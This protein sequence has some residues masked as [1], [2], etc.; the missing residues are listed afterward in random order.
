LRTIATLPAPEGLEDRVM[1]ALASTRQSARGLEWR[2]ISGSQRDWLR[3]AAAAAIVFVVAGGGWGIYSRVQPA[4]PAGAKVLA[5][6]HVGAQ[7]GFSSA[8]AMRMPQTLNG[9]AAP[10]AAQPG[11][12]AKSLH[13]A[14][15]G[16]GQK[17]KTIKSKTSVRALATSVN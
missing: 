1:D 9:P 7:S 3:A 16:S 5:P 12:A 6:A 10:V 17:G 15:Q 13:K 8:G 2:V 11:G 14:G 4:E